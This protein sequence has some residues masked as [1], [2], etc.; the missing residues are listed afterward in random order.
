VPSRV[1][2]TNINFDTSESE[3]IKQIVFTFNQN[4]AVIGAVPSNNQIK[5]VSISNGLDKSCTWRFVTLNQMACE[6]N[7]RLKYLSKYKLTI[8]KSFTA[9]G[10]NLS[11]SKTVNISTP[12]PPVRI[13]YEGEYDYFP[14]SITLF[15]NTN[16]RRVSINLKL[17]IM[18]LTACIKKLTK[19]KIIDLYPSMISWIRNNSKIHTSV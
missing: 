16:T 3:S 13:D 11:Q 1:F 14:S 7:E 17:L 10:N 5:S 9:L 4:V 8:K 6:L 18:N 2:V 15:D 12:V 19:E